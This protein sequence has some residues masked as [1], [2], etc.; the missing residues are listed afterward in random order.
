MQFYQDAAGERTPLP[1]PNI[2]TGMGLERAAVI[3]QGKRSI[4]E[5]DLFEGLVR[6]AAEL[7]GRPYG[8]N[9]DDDYALRVVAEH[10]RSAAFLICD[11]VV[12][13]NGGRNYVLRRVIRRAIRY[14]RKLGLED[15]FLSQVA[16]VVIDRMGAAYPDLLER[17]E[18]I[19]RVMGLEEERFG[20]ALRDGPADEWRKG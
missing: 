7:C 3:L 1:A 8:R 17:R 12:P 2:D 6:S 10:A 4:Y 13:G 18:F 15:P 19:L 11:G 9:P 5:T 14:G 20:Q 16:Q